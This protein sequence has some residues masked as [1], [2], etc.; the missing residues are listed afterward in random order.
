MGELA[1]RTTA[2]AADTAGNMVGQGVTAVCAIAGIAMDSPVL[3]AAGLPLGALVGAGATEL[4]EAVAGRL[5]R[6]QTERVMAFCRCAEECADLPL[7]Q[8][9]EM[10]AQDAAILDL[11]ARAAE[12]SKLSTEALK[13][14]VFA[15]AFVASVKD[16]ATVDHARI[17]VEELAQLQM[18]HLRL[19]KVLHGEPPWPT[20]KS[21]TQREVWG[22]ALILTADPGLAQ[23]FDALIAKLRGVGMVS[24]ESLG[25][26]VGSSSADTMWKLTQFGKACATWLVQMSTSSDGTA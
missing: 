6:N 7:E 9:L 2:V 11:L 16:P 15:R 19:L 5:W 25:L 17:I 26:T 1:E 3:A 21:E 24:E 18:G 8:I 20:A 12:A 13:I 4:V 22:R 14:R 10:A 23:A